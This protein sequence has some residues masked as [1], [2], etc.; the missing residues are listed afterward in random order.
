MAIFKGTPF[1]KAKMLKVV[2]ID[3]NKEIVPM[4]SYL[5]NKVKISLRDSIIK[6]SD[7][8]SKSNGECE[9]ITKN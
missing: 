3:T 2:Q 4:Y 7:I 5:I 9:C 1:N 6:R 8:S